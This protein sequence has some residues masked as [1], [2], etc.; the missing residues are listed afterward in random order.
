MNTTLASAITKVASKQTYYTIRFLV[1]RERIDDAYRT[2]GYFCWIDDVIDANSVS[3]NERKSFLKRQK[4]LLQNCYRGDPPRDIDMQELLLVELA[5]RDC[6][7]DSGLEVY[8]HNIMQVMDFDARRRGRLISQVELN[9]YTRWLATAVTENLHYF[10]GH[11]RFAPRHET[12]YLA[13]SAAHITHRLRD[14]YSGL[15]AG[16]YNIPR[17][18]LEANRIGPEDVNSDAYRA[19]AKSRVQLAR[20]YFKAGKSYLPRVQS[21]RCRLAGYAY[22]ARFEWLLNTIEEENYLLRPQ[23]SERK[24]IETGLRMGLSILSSLTCRKDFCFRNLLHDRVALHG[25]LERIRDLNLTLNS[26]S[27]CG[28]SPQNCDKEKS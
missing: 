19:W 13:V 15:Q 18:V 11:G 23:Y 3:E 8:L 26:I 12:R 5:Q 20:E 24:R 14:T 7:Q 6:E 9:Q 10:I 25:L 4:S 2:Y 27:L 22:I 17:E 28:L 21:L 16:Y 1:D